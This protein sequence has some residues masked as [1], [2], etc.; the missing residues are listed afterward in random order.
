MS[1]EL[2]TP[3]ELISKYPNLIVHGW[4]ERFITAM[5]KKNL[6]RGKIRN[7]N[8]TSF[9]DHNSFIKLVMFMND[10]L[11]QTKIQL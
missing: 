9:I 8:N 11:D 4:D 10:Q 7:G 5:L 2:F 3:K 1:Q 6:L